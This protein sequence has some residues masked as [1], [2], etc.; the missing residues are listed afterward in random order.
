MKNRN[1]KIVYSSFEGPQKRA[2][3]VISREIGSMI[4]RDPGIYSIYS[5]PCFRAGGCALD[6]NAIVIGRVEENSVLAR[7][8][9]RDDVPAGGYLVRIIDNPD[10]PGCR[11]VLIAGDTPAAVLWGAFD[12]IDDGIPA[13]SPLFDGHNFES[14][15]FEGDAPLNPYE[16]RRS[17]LSKV[18]SVFFWGHTVDDYEKHFENLA[19]LKFNEVIIWNDYPPVNAR[20][21]VECAHSWGIAVIW[22]FAWGWSIDCTK[23]D[24]DT[25]EAVGDKVVDDWRN[26]WKPLGGDGIYFQTFTETSNTMIGGK[27]IAEVVTEFVNATCARILAESPDE[28]IEFGLHATSVRTYMSC[29]GRVDP[30]IEIIWED[31]GGFPYKTVLPYDPEATEAFTLEMISQGR[32]MGLVF[33][34]QAMLD[35]SRNRFNHQ[36]GPYIFGRAGE[37]ILRQDIESLEQVW[38]HYAVQWRERGEFAY[39]LA[40]LIHEKGRGQV[41][42]NMVGNL[43]GPIHFPTALC[44]ELFWSTDE[45]YS[46][47]LS[48]I[49]RRRCVVQ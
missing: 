18:R 2:V 19:R 4:L 3:E 17:P 42:M 32:P 1:W 46:A 40:K 28:R 45:S 23:F 29:I 20:D 8:L 38:R 41:T 30:R 13:I 5:L 33:K 9:R 10:A 48:R 22:G 47:I 37:A 49:A 43:V 39:R 16:S 24:L 35:W 31:C 6:G 12:F 14:D 21:V 15:I 34:C 11:L 26:V 25:L 7:F 36:Q 44:A 27:P